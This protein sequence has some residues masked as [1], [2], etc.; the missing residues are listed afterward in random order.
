MGYLNSYIGIIIFI[1]II[2][3]FVY[4]IQGEDE[5]HQDSHGPCRDS[6]WKLRI[7]S[8]ANHGGYW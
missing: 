5:I 8:K 6:G 7:R 1:I 2:I 4:F 3:F